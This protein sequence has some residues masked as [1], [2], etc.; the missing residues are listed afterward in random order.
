MTQQEL[1]NIK[2]RFGIIGTNPQL[3]H[4]IEVAVQVAMT[5]LSVLVTGESGVGKEFFPQII[6]AFSTR[7]HGP[8]FAVNCGAIPEGTIDSE[9]FGHEKGA[10]TDAKAD[11]KGYF[12][13]ANGGTLFLD[14]VGELPLSTQVRLL[15][16]LE[17][18][19]F[20]KMG[21]SQ[22]LK[23]NVRVVAATNLDMRQAIQNG[24]FREDLYYRLNSVE[25]KVP[26]L[27]ERREDIPL[28]FR[29]F[30]VDFGERY[31]MPPLRL[32]EEATALLQSYYWNGNVRQL[33]NVAEQMSVLESNRDI[34]AATLRNY[35]PQNEAVQ[36]LTRVENQHAQDNFINERE[37]LYK[38]LFDMKND[39][40]Q[41]RQQLN[42]LMKA[43]PAAT[44]SSIH[45][46]EYQV[47]EEISP[48]QPISIAEMEKETIRKALDKNGGNRKAAAEELGFSE[49]TLYRK[50]KDYGL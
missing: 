18:G 38:V 22:V 37:L 47:A 20:I 31:K 14:E 49:R 33:K 45:Q 6:H 29:K 50:I 15:R 48:E 43:R 4:A 35:L 8:Y 11:R 19:E 40:N 10:F 34:T 12:E 32:S 16:V 9:L 24:R 39:M 1:L 28:L 26:A 21:S 36:T 7:K 2:Q 25:I 17:T 41:M 44:S 27:R 42:E 23:T 3:H 5:D 30:A 13:I 46:Q